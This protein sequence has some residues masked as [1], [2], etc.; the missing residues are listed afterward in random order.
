LTNVLVLAGNFI[1]LWH[2]GPIWVFLAIVLALVW[3][4]WDR[5]RNRSG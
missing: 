1:A 4:V 5:R 2:D 3:F